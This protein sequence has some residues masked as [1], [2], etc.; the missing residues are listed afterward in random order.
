MKGEG[1]LSTEGGSGVSPVT[2]RCACGQVEFEAHGRP[3]TSLTCYCDDCREGSRQ[4]EALPGARRVMDGNEGSPYSLWRKDRVVCVKGQDLLAA[5]KVRPSSHTNRIVA[6]C[7][8]SALMLGFD[9]WRPWVSVYRVAIAGGLPP[10][11]LRIFTKFASNPAELP[12]DVPRHVT[13]PPWFPLRML[14]ERLSMIFRSKG[15]A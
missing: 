6:A 3:I 8:N 7:C 11:R 12:Q 5:H 10:L 9:G 14:L 4:V 13:F 2:I 15:P 1:A